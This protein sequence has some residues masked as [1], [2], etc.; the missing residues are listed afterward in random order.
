[1]SSEDGGHIDLAPFG[2]WQRNTCQ[3]LV[4]VGNHGLGL[5]VADELSWEL[6]AILNI[7]DTALLKERE[8][9]PLQETKRPNIRK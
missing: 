8:R 4:E 2:Q 3:P 6:V 7:R 1:M 5:F 9:L